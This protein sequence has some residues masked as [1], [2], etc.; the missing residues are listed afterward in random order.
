M[1]LLRSLLFYLYFSIVTIGYSLILVTIGLVLPFPVR[2]RLGNAWGRDSLFG[3]KH[4]CG[5]D[6]RVTGLEHLKRDGNAMVLS[7]HQSAWETIALRMLVP[8]N[9]SWVLKRELLYVPFFGWGL[10]M[11]RPIAINRGSPNQA[12]KQ[13]LR[14]GVKALNRGQWMIIFPEGTRVAPGEKRRYGASGAMLAMK[15]AVDVIPVAHNAGLYWRRNALRK[16][17]GTIELRIG[18]PISTSDK[19]AQ[20][21]MDEVEEWIES[22][23]EKI[24]KAADS[25]ANS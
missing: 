18:E 5:L 15:A 14:D 12:L 8:S 22:E 2:S 24:G 16:Y 4:I 20:Q 13:V 17:P 6:Y 19:S 3:L 23:M 10:A 11:F 25:V 21:I 1:I 9:Q 7:K